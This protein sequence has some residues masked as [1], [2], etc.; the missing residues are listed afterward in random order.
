VE[1]V[2]APRQ[3]SAREGAHATILLHEGRRYE[4]ALEGLEGFEYLWVVF[5]FHRN[6]E[7]G[8]GWRPKVLPP[9][10]ET[11]RGLFA[12]RSPHRPN[13]IG[14]SVVRLDRIEGLSI[15]V[16]NADI[17]DGSPVL[18][19]KPYIAYADA[20]PDAKEGWLDVRDPKPAWEI[21]WSDRA[22]AARDLLASWGVDLSE[23]E[24]LLSLGPQPHAY[25]R[26]RKD[27]SRMRLAYREWRVFFRV[28]GARVTIEE[29]RSGYRPS[30]I[31]SDEALS[32]HA[33]LEAW[34]KQGA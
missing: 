32:T 22:R 28:Q 21:A 19:I 16:S 9:R 23:V 7:E 27:G 4:D 2:S 11:K 25:R 8:R 1:R 33:R 34:W 31:A 12:T 30:Q 10:S 6:V 20:Y 3:P 5:V 15:H 17:L 18:D 13:P 24:R 14:L 29:V 26:I